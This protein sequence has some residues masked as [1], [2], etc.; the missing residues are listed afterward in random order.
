[1]RINYK[2]TKG[3]RVRRHLRVR[4]KIS[5][6]ASCPRMCVSITA[7]NIYVQ[8]IDD[9]SGVT[10]ASTSS[11]DSKVKEQNIKPNLAGAEII[12]K[13]AAEKAVALNIE[14]IVFDRS[15]FRYHGR[16]KAIAE[17]ARKGGLKF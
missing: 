12:G 14:K 3:K 16:V 4:R 13:L 8:F 6:T 15:G 17:A 10:L 7:N 5:G 1:M 11:L 2:T 9:E